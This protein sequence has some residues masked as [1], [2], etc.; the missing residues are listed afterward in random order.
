MRTPDARSAGHSTDA[1]A[2]SSRAG[3]PVGVHALDAARGQCVRSGAQM[4]D[5]RDLQRA[6]PGPELADCEGRN[7]LERCNE[8][9]QPLG[10]KTTRAAT[11]QLARQRENAR[12][13][14]ELIARDGREF[15]EKRRWQ[16]LVN[17][18]RRR[19]DDVKV[20]EQPL[21]RGRG[22]LAAPGVVGQLGVDD[23]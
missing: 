4:F 9:L 23:A 5:Q 6:W 16:I 7:R 11:D 21:R 8:A 14:R 19:R 12:L 10:V 1:E 17:I 3:E 13:T 22:G 2:V 15:S 18:A 20:V